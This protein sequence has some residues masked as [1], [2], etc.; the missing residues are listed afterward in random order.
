MKNIINII[1][2]SKPLH[3]LVAILAILI[4]LSS[5]LQL[6]AP[7]LSKFIVDE[8][9]SQVQNKGGDIT[10]LITLIVIAFVTSFSGLIITVISERIGDHFAGK[11]RQFLTEKFLFELSLNLFIKFHQ[12]T[13]NLSENFF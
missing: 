11:L 10:R 13:I 9:V 6:V 4:L 8:I 3:H 2:I 5:S 12:L 1:K 7:I